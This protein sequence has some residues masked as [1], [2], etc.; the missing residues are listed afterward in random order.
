MMALGAY[1]MQSALRSQ[2]KKFCAQKRW[3]FAFLKLAQGVYAGVIC[4]F[5]PGPQA[6]ICFCFFNAACW[7]MPISQL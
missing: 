3:F 2:Q 4:F 6:E 1:L 5:R 7:A